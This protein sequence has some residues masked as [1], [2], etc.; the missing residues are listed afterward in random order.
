M[1]PKFMAEVK[2]WNGESYE[3]L[4]KMPYL[5]LHSPKEEHFFFEGGWERE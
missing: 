1:I 3:N 2:R 4:T 5:T